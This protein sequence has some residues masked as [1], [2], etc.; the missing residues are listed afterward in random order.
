M[1]QYDVENRLNHWATWLLMF[2]KNL[3]GYPSES[4]ISKFQDG[5]VQDKH[6]SR[7][8]TEPYRQN[9]L[10]ENVNTA[11]NRLKLYSK[12]QATA[13]HIYY[14]KRVNVKKYAQK[15]N[16]SPSTFYKHLRAARL[17]IEGELERSEK[18]ND[19]RA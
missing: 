6:R 9:K 14:I 3:L 10:A 15:K 17:W 13:I 5:Y 1:A 12:S 18:T 2:K 16:M 11:Y 4:I 19:N 8:S 7:G